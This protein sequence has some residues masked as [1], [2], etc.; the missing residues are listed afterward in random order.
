MQGF[1]TWAVDGHGWIAIVG[2]VM[3]VLGVAW[4]KS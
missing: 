3:L 2:V 1:M 4:R